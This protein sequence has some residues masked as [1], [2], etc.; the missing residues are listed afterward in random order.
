MNEKLAILTLFCALKLPIVSVLILNIKK[1]TSLAFV[2]KYSYPLLK[3]T[4]FV[5]ANSLGNKFY[6]LVEVTRTYK[7]FFLLFYSFSLS[8]V[9]FGGP[10]DLR[11]VA[12]S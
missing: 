3:Q 5:I 2:G 10:Y 7:T 1:L 8:S 4:L 9:I 11:Y 12:L 6:T